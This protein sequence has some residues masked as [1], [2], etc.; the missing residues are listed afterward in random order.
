MTI[1]KLAKTLG[2]K[3]F[4]IQQLRLVETELWEIGSKFGIK[5]LEELDQKIA[6]GKIKETEVGEDFF[7]FDFLLEKKRELEKALKE[8]TNPSLNLWE[9]IRNSIGSPRWSLGI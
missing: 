4:L 9:S 7:R 8:E 2:P 3:V 6:S 5:T 1:S